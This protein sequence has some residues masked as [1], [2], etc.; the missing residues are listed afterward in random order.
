MKKIAHIINSKIYSGL[1]NV[2]VS[3]ISELSDK[4]E[5]VYVT[6]DGPIVDILIEKNIPYYIIEKMSVKEIKK[7]IKNWNPDIIH[8]H[9]FTASVICASSNI[10]KPII[11]HLHNNP[12]WLSKISLNSLLY[13]FAASK[14]KRILVVSK[15]I[16]REFIFSNII[17]NKIE[18][19]DNPVDRKK[20]LKNTNTIDTKKIY[21]I[22]CVARITECKN[23]FRF[24]EIINLLKEKKHIKA[25]WVGDGD[26]LEICQRKIDELNLKDN[27][28]FV[29]FKKNPFEYIN[30]SKI[31]VLTSDWEGYGL[32]AFE[33]LTL[34]VPCVVSNVGGLPGIVDY[35]CG[36]LCNNEEQ[37]VEEINKLLEDENYYNNKKINAI[38]KSE[39]LENTKNYMANLEKIYLAM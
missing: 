8:A 15:A 21:D 25:V 16:Q 7:F 22:C 35:N 38:K 11:N 29:G 4:Y 2:V 5:M 19:I 24:I 17:K 31:F 34:G 30:N 23:P 18:I 20:V 36:K 39:K 14:A 12:K 27:I 26:L 37:F 33:A 6:Q 3:I 13:L 28:S 9:D 10:K 1:E 32:V